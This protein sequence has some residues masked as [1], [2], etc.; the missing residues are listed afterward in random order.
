MSLDP[1]GRYKRSQPTIHHSRVWRRCT[2]KVESFVSDGRL[3]T[4]QGCCGPILWGRTQ[5]GEYVALD[6]APDPRGQYVLLRDGIS[7]FELPLE[8]VVAETDEARAASKN[9]SHRHRAHRATCGVGPGVRHV[10]DSAR[11]LF[12]GDTRGTRRPR[13]PLV[14][15]RFDPPT[16]RPTVSCSACGA[17]FVWGHSPADGWIPLDVEPHRAG[18][19]VFITDDRDDPRVEP[20]GF[21]AR[22]DR[23]PRYKNHHLTC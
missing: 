15:D 2:G 10:S 7:A 6:P 5:Q 12:R 20:V 8:L 3:K 13:Q 14:P 21:D 23:R 22:Q 9:A 1:S 17:P 4:C 16:P 19:L 18:L 11:R